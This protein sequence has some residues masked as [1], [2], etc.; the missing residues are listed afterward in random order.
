MESGPVVRA[1]LE[2]LEKNKA[3]AIP[4]TL[5]KLSGQGHRLLPRSA[6]RKIAGSIKF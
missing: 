5:N 4:G 2:A 6:V 3:V 1:G